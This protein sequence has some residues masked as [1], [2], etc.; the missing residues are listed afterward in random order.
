ML[1]CVVHKIL[2]QICCQQAS[3]CLH[4]TDPFR[5]GKHSLQFDDLTGDPDIDFFERRCGA[6]ACP[7]HGQTSVDVDVHAPRP[8]I[9]LV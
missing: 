5:V 4:D 6:G 2:K 1:C 7:R 8:C 9:S 3:T